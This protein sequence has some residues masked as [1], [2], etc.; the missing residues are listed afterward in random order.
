MTVNIWKSYLWTADD[1]MNMKAIFVNSTEQQ[2]KL[3]LKNF[4]PVWNLNPWPLWYQYSI[5]L[6]EL[7]NQPGAGHFGGGNK[8]VKWWNNDC[9][10]FS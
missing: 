2:E 3:G 8:P 10:S 9:C 6:T 4:R 1:E 7:T 5:L